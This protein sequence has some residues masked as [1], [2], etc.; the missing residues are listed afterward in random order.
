MK[1]EPIVRDFGLVD[2]VPVWKRMARFAA[3]AGPETREEIWLLSHNPVFTLGQAAKEEHLLAPGAVPVIQTDRGGQVTYHG[4]GQ[5]VVYPLLDLRRR[6]MGIRQ[7]V[8]LI[9]T[10]LIEALAG[11]GITAATR[12]G[13]P[14][15]FVGEAKIAALGLR[16]RRGW[17]Y[18][19]LSLNVDMDLAPFSSINPCGFRGLEVT[20]VA[21]LVGGKIG[22]MNRMK[23]LLTEASM[24]QL[25]R[26]PLRQGRAEKEEAAHA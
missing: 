16:I 8:D 22:L 9:E 6:G 21:D 11:A 4:P 17:S 23:T 19:G 14:G 7:L 5:L 26:F 20:R 2:Y 12:P 10:A 24:R 3:T 1:H 25:E 15:V 18:H 13:A